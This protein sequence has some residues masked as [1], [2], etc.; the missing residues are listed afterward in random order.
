MCHMVI[1][2]VGLMFVEADILRTG[3]E[4][5]MNDLK[6]GVIIV[7]QESGLVKFVNN[8]AKRF[9][10]RKNRHLGISMS[11]QDTEARPNINDSIDSFDK[12]Q[13]L[14]AQI[15]MKMMDTGLNQGTGLDD[16]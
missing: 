9:S 3:N 12:G 13:E 6:E 4:L 16:S 7:D 10:I 15:D 1:N 2:A 8:A 5:L 11:I 14:F